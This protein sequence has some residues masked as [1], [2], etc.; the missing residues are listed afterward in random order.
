[1]KHRIKL[2]L[3]NFSKPY[4]LIIYK[5]YTHANSGYIKDKNSNYLLGT[6]SCGSI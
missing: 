3:H 4:V 6:Y 5:Y 1:M 2:T